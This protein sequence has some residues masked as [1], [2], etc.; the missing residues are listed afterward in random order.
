MFYISGARVA[1]WS[2]ALLCVQL[3]GCTGTHYI[4]DQG[5]L[6][7]PAPA[8]EALNSFS[9]QADIHLNLP[10]GYA[11]PSV[12]QY[13]SEVA[14]AEVNRWFAKSG[15]DL[16]VSIRNDNNKAVSYTHLTLPTIYSV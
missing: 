15:Q 11:S 13:P 9:G 4:P 16:T 8:P 2:T 3:V 5:Q 10:G 7:S 6:A 1:L 12:R 14:T